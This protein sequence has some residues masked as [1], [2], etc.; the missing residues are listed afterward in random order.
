MFSSKT[1][2]SQLRDRFSWAWLAVGMLL[3][4]FTAF[5][6]VLPL[7]AWLA[8][9]F[10]LRFVRT[11]RVVIGLPAVALAYG[12]GTIIAFREILPPPT[13]Y[14]VGLL[15]MI[16]VIPYTLDRWMGVRLTSIARTLIFPLTVTLLDWIIA[17]GPLGSGMTA[18]YSQ[19]G[20]LPLMQLASVTGV[21]G[22]TFLIAWFAPVANE[23][24]EHAADWRSA[25][26]ALALFTAV[27]FAV[28]LF[29]SARIAFAANAPSTLRV[30]GLTHDKTLW[31]SLSHGIIDVARG[32]DVVRSEMRTQYQLILDDLFARTQRE[33][34]AGAQLV[35]WSEVAAYILQED[36]TE[37]LERAR[38]LARQEHIY[39]QVA[40]GVVLRTQQHPYAQNRALLIDPTGTVIWDYYKT[41]HPFGDNA[42]FAPGPGV[43][44]VADTP[45]GRL[46]TVICF[47]ADYPEL[48]RQVGQSGADILL[49]PS[50]D[51]EAVKRMHAGVA[52]FRAIEN[53]VAM[54]RPTGDGISLVTDSLGRVLATADDFVTVTPAMVVDTPLHGMS[55]IYAK[56]GDLFVYLCAAGWLLLAVAAL[57]RCNAARP[58]FVEQPAHV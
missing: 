32:S 28:T 54:V 50:H 47:D 53:G 7:A 26:P 16:V 14:S 8:P 3:L 29:G 33:A 30:A 41:V 24:W 49:V 17:F 45:F 57:W 34:R 37:V 18:G 5:E 4:P 23:L 46:A 44:P 51:W 12:A 19:Y 39:L 22:I 56:A 43:I 13:N 2:S 11:Q 52:V 55:T 40:L 35:A 6:A 58:T 10:L 15:S 42:V 48:L 9:V 21:W 25:W 1:S 38:A 27:V 20:N 36:E 31:A